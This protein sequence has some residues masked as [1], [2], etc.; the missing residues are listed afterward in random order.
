MNVE[1]F[2]AGGTGGSYVANVKLGTGSDTIVFDQ[3]ASI[4]AD[5][6]V[7]LDQALFTWQKTWATGT[8]TVRLIP[9]TT[10]G[11]ADGFRICWLTQYGV[12]NR[13][14]CTVHGAGY[15]TSVV[16]DY[17]GSGMAIQSSINSAR[18]SSLAFA[19]PATSRYEQATTNVS[20]SYGSQEA[21][22]SGTLYVSRLRN[23]ALDASL[24]EW[25][26][27]DARARLILQSIDGGPGGFRVCWLTQW[28]T[29]NRLACNVDGVPGISVHLI[30]D[31]LGNVVTFR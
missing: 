4:G 22:L 7:A 15:A 16:D 24:A 12:L 25:T 1:F 6:R 30:D 29:L 2:V 11:M 5:D 27:G 8:A 17:F 13:L 20:L 10:E 31:Y 18:G 9:Q 21:A 14:A 28:Q 23:Y 26:S 3:V 19:Q